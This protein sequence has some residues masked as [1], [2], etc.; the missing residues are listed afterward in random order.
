MNNTNN[1]NK[2]NSVEANQRIECY[3]Q[4]LNIVTTIRFIHEAAKEPTSSE[5]KYKHIIILYKANGGD[6]LNK[7]SICCAIFCKNE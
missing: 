5:Q 6:R 7:V 4:Y 3:T 2:K 1:N